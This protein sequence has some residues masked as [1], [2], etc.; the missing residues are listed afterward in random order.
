ME[1]IE[2]PDLISYRERYRV[3]EHRGVRVQDIPTSEVQVGD[4]L[5]MWLADKSAYPTVTGWT[6]R[7]LDLGYLGHPV[8]RTFTLRDAP[9][10]VSKA[11]AASNLDNKIYVLALAG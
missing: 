1:H 5:C 2:N 3:T 4:R 10:W 7:E 8:H 6:D 9:W 11:D